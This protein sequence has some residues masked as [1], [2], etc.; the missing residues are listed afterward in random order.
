[1]TGWMNT[2]DAQC[3]K[4][5]AI[6]AAPVGYI[7]KSVKCT[8]CA[9]EFVGEPMLATPS[10]PSTNSRA[11][12]KMKEKKE[13]EDGADT[14]ISNADKE[15]VNMRFKDLPWG[16]RYALSIGAVTIILNFSWGSRWEYKTASPS[17]DNLVM[18]M[19]YLG[20]AGWELVSSRRAT[21]SDG[22]VSYEFIFKKEKTLHE[23]I[24]GIF[25]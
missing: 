13:R 7:G 19:D 1:M 10:R 2:F 22:S 21:G 12:P 6:L 18:E 16:W 23:K 15:I 11:T 20:G 17:D 4:C 24:T 8:S 25:R 3:P 9:R 5:N 14:E